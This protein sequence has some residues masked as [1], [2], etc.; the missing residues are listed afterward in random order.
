MKAIVHRVY[1]SPDALG[2]EEVDKPTPGRGEVLIR[3]RAAGVNPLDWHFMRGLPYAVRMLAGWRQPK[4]TRFGQDVAGEIEA[5]GADVKQ[6][7]VGDRVFGT[8]R[9]A[10][11]EFACGSERTFTR[12]PENVTFE[13]AAAA[14]IAALTALQTLRDK[15]RI[16]AGHKVLVNGAAGGVGTF[17]VQIAKSLGAEVTGVCSATNLGMVQSIGADH[18]VDYAREDFSQSARRY[19]VIL[20]C[21]ANH[22]LAAYRRCMNPEGRYVSVGRLDGGGRWMMGALWSGF[23]AAAHSSVGGKRF[24]S[25]F[26]KINKQDLESLQELLRTGR[27]KPVIDRCYGLQEVAEAIRYVERRHARGKVMIRP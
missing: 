18:V 13:E 14:P 16:E 4:D 15:G 21:V 10:F 1:G 7:N 26:A 6:F 20:D 22:S 25:I 17:A 12:K 3:V 2:L 8:C 19:D 23:A 5:L 27:V 9:G 24:L 11:A